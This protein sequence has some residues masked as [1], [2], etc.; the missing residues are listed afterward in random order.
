M[1]VGRPARLAL[2]GQ[3]QP[4]EGVARVGDA[5]AAIGRGAILLDIASGQ[6][7]TAQQHRRLDAGA[8]HLGQVF[9]HD[10]RRLDQ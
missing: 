2:I 3:R 4:V 1:L 8:G 7:R 6:R 9:A 5:A 10:D